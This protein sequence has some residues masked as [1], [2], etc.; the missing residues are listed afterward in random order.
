MPSFIGNALTRALAKYFAG[1]VPT[2]VEEIN[3]GMNYPYFYLWINLLHSMVSKKS[4]LL[5]HY[6]PSC[7]VVYMYGKNKPM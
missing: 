1:H 4:S 5:Y 3:N 2:Y 6:K 7:K